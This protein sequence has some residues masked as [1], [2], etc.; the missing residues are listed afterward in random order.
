M[1]AVDDRGRDVLDRLRAI[2]RRNGLLATADTPRAE[3]ELRTFVTLPPRYAAWQATR[4]LPRPPD[5]VSALWTGD[6]PPPSY[7]VFDPASPGR[8]SP[9]RPVRLRITS[10]ENGLRLLRD[11]ETPAELSTLALTVIVDPPVPQVVW[12]VD[13][14]SYETVPAASH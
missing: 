10:P 12:Y 13:G 2:D 6:G 14:Q 3:I 4:D 11:P 5:T 7:A 9:D 8:P 1:A